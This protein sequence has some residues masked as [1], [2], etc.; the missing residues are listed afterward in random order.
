MK[1]VNNSKTAVGIK[2]SFSNQ[3]LTI[4]VYGNPILDD[5]ITLSMVSK[6]VKDLD[7]PAPVYEEDPTL[8]PGIEVEA[9]AATLG[10]RWVTNLVTKKDGVVVE[11]I[12]LHNSTYKGKSATIKRNTSGTVVSTEGESSSEES[13]PADGNGL[14]AHMHIHI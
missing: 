12:L 13:S 10:S 3:K 2:T 4:S 7:A 6:K 5:G 1:F 9:K 8:E 14:S 11:E